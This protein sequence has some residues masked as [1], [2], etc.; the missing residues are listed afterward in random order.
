MTEVNLAAP[1][2]FIVAVENSS[3]QLGAGLMTSLRA[4]SPKVKISGVGG[5]AMSSKGLKSKFDISG[6]SILGFF[7]AVRA[8]TLVLRRVKETVSAIMKASPDTVVLIDS[9][10]F[11][12]RVSQRLKNAGYKG[13]IIKY[14]APQV[15]AM[16]EGRARVLAKSNDHVL[17]IHNFDAPYFEQHGLSVSHIGNP[18]FDTDYT[19]GDGGLL[20]SRL[21]C[22][23]DAPLCAVFF[24]SRVSEINQLQQPIAAAVEKL[25]LRYPDMQFVSP[26]ADPMKDK[27][28]AAKNIGT[29]RQITLVSEAEKADV[30]K[31]ADVAI[32]CS[33]TV[34]TQLASVGV[35]TVVIYKLKPLSWWFAKRLFK[36]DYISLVNISADAALMPELLQSEASG[37]NIA[38]EISEFIDDSHKRQTCSDALRAEARRMKGGDGLASDK[39]AAQILKLIRA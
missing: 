31:A 13:P 7:E 12:I 27:V 5:P 28:H 38:A 17:S 19:V 1:H 14:V 37:E 3:D 6:L 9:W 26:V 36:P 34:T 15:W 25:S 29:F 39:A 16:R 32:A 8:Y 4:Q 18:M 33:G 11:M 24:G 22:E 35:P 10:G 20:R 23:N 30:F 21:S 2:I